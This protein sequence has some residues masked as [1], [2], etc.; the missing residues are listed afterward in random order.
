[1][2]LKTMKRLTGVL[3][4]LSALV[5]CQHKWIRVTST[6]RVIGQTTWRLP[7]TSTLI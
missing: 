4:Q 1:M 6:Q 3:R 7:R 5:I 2:S